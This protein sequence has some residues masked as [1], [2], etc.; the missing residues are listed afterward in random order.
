MAHYIFEGGYKN[1][2]GNVLVR[3]LLFHFEDENKVCGS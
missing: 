3:L 2:S 1:K